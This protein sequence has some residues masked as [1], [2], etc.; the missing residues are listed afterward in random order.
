MSL[1]TKAP[2]QGKVEMLLRGADRAAGLE[3]SQVPALALTFAGIAG[4]C[5]SGL[6]RKS[7]TRTL[8]LYRR[9]TDIRN[10]RQLSLLSTEE[11][12]EVASAMGVAAVKPEWVGANLVTSGIPDLTTLPPSTRLQF[13]SGATLAVDLENAPCRFVADVIAKY[14][15]DAAGRWVKAATHKRGVTAWVE[16]EGEVRL[17]DAIALFL[18]PRRLYAHG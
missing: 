15:S 13:P 7:D 3:K 1:I 4:D 11:L 2:F 10:V 14:H 8:K 6:T 12:A 17:G 16:R 18:P 9:D 5:H